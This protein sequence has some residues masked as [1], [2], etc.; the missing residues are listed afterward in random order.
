MR[1]FL[2]M[3]RDHK[4]R[5]NSYNEFRDQCA[6]SSDHGSHRSTF[7]NTDKIQKIRRTDAHDLLN[8]L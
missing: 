2:K 7:R 3:Q 4:Q 1:I 8:K 6:A 5:Q